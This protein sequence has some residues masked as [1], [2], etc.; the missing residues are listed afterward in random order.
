MEGMVVSTRKDVNTKFYADHTALTYTKAG[1]TA[2]ANG[3]PITP[4]NLLNGLIPA[5]PEAAPLYQCL[6]DVFEGSS[7][8]HRIAEALRV[9]SADV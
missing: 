9:G 2:S 1:V 3:Y 7:D 5:P 6:V 4:A 8:A